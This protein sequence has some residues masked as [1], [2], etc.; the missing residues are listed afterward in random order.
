MDKLKNDYSINLSV[1]SKV[2]I[3]YI[4]IVRMTLGQYSKKKNYTENTVPT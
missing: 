4:K 1:I 2:S 3:Y